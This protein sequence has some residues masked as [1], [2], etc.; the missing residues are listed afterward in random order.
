MIQDYNHVGQA[1]FWLG[2]AEEEEIFN[3]YNNT[4]SDSSVGVE[5]FQ[6]YINGKYEAVFKR[7]T[8]RS[9]YIQILLFSLKG[10]KTLL[11]DGGMK[12]LMFVSDN[13]ERES[14]S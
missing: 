6:Y 3:I 9:M 5:M 10:L 12:M 4:L 7:A 2:G 14:D 11:R 8:K 1:S 13:V